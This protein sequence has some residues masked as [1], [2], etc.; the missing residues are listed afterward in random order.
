VA[1][2]DSYSAGEGLGPFE[3][4][5]DVDKGK[6]RNQCHRSSKDAYPVLTPAVVL[7][8]VTA[9]ASF[10]CS[11]ATSADMRATPPQTG[12]S[13]QVGQPQQT[14]TV[15]S[16]TQYITLSA[17]G[18]DVGFGDLGIGCVEA[19]IS[20]KKVVRFS[21]KSCKDQIAASTKK[22]ATANASL[23]SLY[24]DL[25][26]RAPQATIVVLGY[27]RVLPATYKGVPKLKGSQFCILDHYPVP[28]VDVGLPVDQAKLLDQFSV[29]LNATVQ[30]AIAKVRQ[31]RPAQASQLRYADSYSSSVP[32]NCKGT[33]PKATVTAAQLSLGHGLSGRRLSDKIKLA[34]GSSTLHPTKTG[35]KLFAALVQQ[36]FTTTPPPLSTVFSR[37]SP[38][39]DDGAVAPGFP[40]VDSSATGTC[41]E[42]SEVGQAYRCFAGNG[43]FDPCYAVAEPGTGDGTG[44]VCPSS[45]FTNDLYAIE[46]ATGLG[47]LDA[48]T[49]DEPNGVAL[50]N[51]ARCTLAQGAHNADGGGRIVDYYCD[52]NKTAVLRGLHE[53][54]SLWTADTAHT[55]SDYKYTP[56]GNQPI[57]TA[58]MLQH[59]V[60]PANRPV[61][62]AGDATTD[63][64]D[65]S[66]RE[67]HEVNCGEETTTRNASPVEQIFDSGTP[68]YEASLIVT[69]WDNGDALEAGW[70]CTY[71]DGGTLLCQQADS[72][73]V[74][75]PGFFSSPHIRAISVG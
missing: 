25:L 54:G 57:A 4:G 30:D 29:S 10:A 39:T 46:S 70:S 34:V 55:N 36:A 64:L 73:N 74:N 6:G 37:Q 12:A 66:S 14:S 20:H 24:T 32:H 51:G 43:V 65:S 52:D 23:V 60:P 58:V 59:D 47:R 50:A 68:C 45:P 56:A 16:G 8:E 62:D 75:A 69:E 44:V 17:G 38:V 63:E 11:G 67:H 40:V 5:T 41:S 26:D 7:P 15:G 2:G 31:A 72:V 19:V 13:R 33:T 1:L 42:G 3:K 49:F 28:V 61:T 22:L 27:P 71:S 18:N 9:R 53:S 48:S 21:S 35:Q